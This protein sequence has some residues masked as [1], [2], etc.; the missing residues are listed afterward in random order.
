[1]S[2][3]RRDQLAA[4]MLVASYTARN[5]LER[6]G[7]LEADKEL[8]TEEK[9]TQIKIIREEISKVGTEID[10]IKKEITLLNAY[11]VN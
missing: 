2:D 7:A 5:L 9:F 3:I 1:M 11:T 10:S 4:K 6:I 8:T